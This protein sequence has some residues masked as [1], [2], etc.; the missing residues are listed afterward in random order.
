MSR[1]ELIPLPDTHAIGGAVGWDRPLQTFFAQVYRIENGEETAFIWEGLDFREL[2]TPA[3]ALRVVAPY[4]AL[5]E[6]LAQALEVDRLKT[7]GTWDG[8]AQLDAKRFMN[9]RNQT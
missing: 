9:G 1:H 6:G 3:E 7:S 5:P 8:A 4:C 2:K